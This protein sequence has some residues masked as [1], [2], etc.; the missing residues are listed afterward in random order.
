M[1][2]CSLFVRLNSSNLSEKSCK[3]LS[4]V[5]SFQ[6]SNLRQLCLSD[7]NLEDSGVKLLSAALQSP[8][9][10]LESLWSELCL[11]HPT[12]SKICWG[13]GLLDSQLQSV[14]LFKTLKRLLEFFFD[15]IMAFNV[16]FKDKYC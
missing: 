12:L 15:Q 2:L 13:G 7:N 14:K 3:A 5:L 16:H 8:H 9:C 4:S 10:T 6:S 11:F 1:S